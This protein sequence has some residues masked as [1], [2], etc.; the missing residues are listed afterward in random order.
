MNAKVEYWLWLYTLLGP[1]SARFK[2]LFY[3]YDYIE[4]MYENRRTPEFR[5]LLA[6]GEAARIGSVSL[7]AQ[8]ALAEQCAA[9][10]VEILC[11]ADDAY[12]QRLRDTRV[13]PLV[14]FATGDLRALHTRCVAGVGSRRQTPYGR[15]AVRRICDPLCQAGVTLVSGLAYGT[16]ADVHRAALR[17]GGRTI[18]VLGSPI[19]DTY[20]VRHLAL[21]REIEQGGGCVLSEYAPG[22][23]Y[24][25]SFFP[26]RNRIISGLAE[27]VVVFEAA[28]KSGTM[29][30]AGWA[31]D[32][33]REVFAVPGRIDSPM[34]EGTNHLI[35]QGAAPACSAGDI[36]DAMGLGDFAAGEQTMLAMPAQ[37]LLT[38]VR[39]AVAGC[40]Q[41]GEKTLDDLIA[42]AGYPPHELLAE[43]TLMELDGLIEALPG[44]RYRLK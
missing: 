12:P 23:T 6:P 14:L 36:L 38:G 33:G 37:Q 10:G 19:D 28:R 13:P 22:M 16:D 15:E 30:T 20:P 3:R 29:I 21:R 35:R 42:S 1:C 25:K 18:A 44:S 7:S 40:L 32:D 8:R 34:S 17:C 24:Q 41:Q 31:L 5:A 11:Y 4:D 27:A 39:G 26:M 43:L 2:E 9:G